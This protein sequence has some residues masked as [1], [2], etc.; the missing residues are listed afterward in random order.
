M[1]KIYKSIEFLLNDLVAVRVGDKSIT[2]KTFGDIVDL[3]EF[4]PIDLRRR[5][6]VQGDLEWLELK[7][8]ISRHKFEG[9]KNKELKNFNWLN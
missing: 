1:V 2:S 3:S 9:M 4:M 5:S 7:I 8:I 6:V